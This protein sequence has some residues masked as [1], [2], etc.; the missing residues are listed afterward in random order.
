M[1]VKKNC[2]KNPNFP[3][4]FPHTNMVRKPNFLSISVLVSEIVTFMA[5]KKSSS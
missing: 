3:K 4:D 5:K 1:F 2:L